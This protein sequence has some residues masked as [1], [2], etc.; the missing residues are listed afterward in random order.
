[1]DCAL[2]DPA[3]GPVVGESRHWRVV[4]NLNQNLLGKVMIVCRRHVEPI[5]ELTAVEWMDLHQAV[6]RASRAL[7]AAFR[8]VHFNYAFLQNQ[9]RHAHLHV[10]PR[11]DRAL[12]FAGERFEDPDH[13]SG[14]SARTQRLSRQALDV[15]AAEL[16]RVW[17]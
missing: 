2:C 3:L 11:Y 4:L 6:Q 13:P 12:E 5:V 1:M 17:P 16:R 14:A 8:P 9:D 7:I 15:V 10:L